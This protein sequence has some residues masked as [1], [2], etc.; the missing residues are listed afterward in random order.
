MC[1]AWEKEAESSHV[2][3]IFH[4]IGEIDNAIAL[5]SARFTNRVTNIFNARSGEQMHFLILR[6]INYT[7]TRVSKALS[8]HML[9]TQDSFQI[10]VVSLY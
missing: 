10:C 3:W 4:L 8:H 6:V 2:V 9:Y 5:V 7:E 1:Q